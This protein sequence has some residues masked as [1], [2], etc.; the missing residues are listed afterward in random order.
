MRLAERSR[1]SVWQYGQFGQ[2]QGQGIGQVPGD[3][4]AAHH[5]I[6]FTLGRKPITYFAQRYSLVWPVRRPKLLTWVTV[7]PRTPIP[8]KASRSSSS[9]NGLRIAIASGC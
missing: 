7:M 5:A 2:G 8:I 6:V 1:K 4:I 3:A 9:L